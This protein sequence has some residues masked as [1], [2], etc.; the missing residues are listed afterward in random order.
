V[1]WNTFRHRSLNTQVI[2]VVGAVSLGLLAFVF[3]GGIGLGLG[4]LLHDYHDRDL[5]AL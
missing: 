1:L 3:A 5:A 2:S 4:E